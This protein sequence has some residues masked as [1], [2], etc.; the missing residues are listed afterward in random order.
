MDAFKKECLIYWTF[1][2]SFFACQHLPSDLST[3][4]L[5]SKF[6]DEEALADENAGY[7]IAYEH[8]NCACTCKCGEKVEQRFALS[9][10]LGDPTKRYKVRK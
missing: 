6:D 9:L 3:D 2:K 7:P 1:F 4:E 8:W 10:Y 5:I